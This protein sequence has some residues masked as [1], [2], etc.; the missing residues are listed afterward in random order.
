MIS[1]GF[2]AWH[3]DNALCLINEVAL[4]RAGLIL[5]WVTVCGQVYHLG[6][7]PAV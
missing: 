2:V 5:G 7:S 3:S 4:R 6:M 1:T